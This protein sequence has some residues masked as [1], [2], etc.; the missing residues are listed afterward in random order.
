MVEA[1]VSATENPLGPY[2]ARIHGWDDILDDKSAFTHTIA[3]DAIPDL[4]QALL[5]VERNLRH[6]QAQDIACGDCSVCANTRMATEERH[7][8]PWSVHCPI[9]TPKLEAAGLR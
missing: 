2:V 8:Q 7:G 5:R 1:T 4:V 3:L 6:R 9:C